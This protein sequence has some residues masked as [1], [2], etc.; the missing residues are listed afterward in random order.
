MFLQSSIGGHLGCFHLLAIVNDAAMNIHIVEIF[1]QTYVF[2][3]LGYIL[4]QGI[5]GL[6]LEMTHSSMND[7]A[8]RGQGHF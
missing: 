2:I 7:E 8:K 5:A 6:G 3:S 1:A 4:R